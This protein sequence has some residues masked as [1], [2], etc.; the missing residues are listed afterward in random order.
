MKK[1]FQL[2]FLTVL[3]VG[4]GV[5]STACNSSEGWESEPQNLTGTE[6][7]AFS[8]KANAKVLSRLDSVYFSIDLVGGRIFNASPLPYGTR[9][10]SIAVAI[11]ADACSVA[12]IYVTRSGEKQDTVINY[13]TSPDEF[14]DF[15]YGPVRLHLVSA[16]GT[17]Q[18]DYNIAVNVASEVSDSL[19]WDKLQKG[20]MY[21][22]RNMEVSRTVKIKGKA[23]TL[24]SDSR[25]YY[26]K[27][28][29][30]VPAA[31]T[32]GGQWEQE[33]IEPVFTTDTPDVNA[34]RADTSGYLDVETFTA[35][36]EGFLYVIKGNKLYMSTDG[37][38][39]F[40]WVDNDWDNIIAPYR[41]CVL[42]LR[43]RW[44]DWIHV[45]YSPHTGSRERG[46]SAE[47]F[48]FRRMSQAAVFSTKWA[49]KPQIVIAGGEA[50]EGQVYGGAWAY[51]GTK[52]A[53]IN[54][55]L[56]AGTG[57]AMA[58]YPIAE[59]DTMNWT[60]NRREVLIAFGGANEALPLRDVW[61]S[62]DMGVN[63]QKGSSLLQ[64]P[65]YMPFVTGASLLVFDKTLDVNSP[66]ARAVKPITQWECPY[67]YLFGGYDIDGTFSNAYWSGVVNHWTVKPIQ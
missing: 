47:D 17:A 7:T 59:T 63:W 57:Y 20:E 45:E 9:T 16:D 36:E 28:S 44:G 65:E 51:D 23:L 25:G 58:K 61:I 60:V 10:D 55:D 37:G 46:K 3:I 26:A 39:K 21:G 67:L 53:K 49:D 31:Y 27:I 18:R 13:L 62:R 6:V 33:L 29:T 15:S 41:D 11:S 54:D 8:L 50:Y 12:E 4:L 32:G 5:A 56:P 22:T 35:T 38:H 43:Y 19:Y 1:G 24:S 2:Y 52:W 48:P 66:S 40:V 34:S 64:L 14:V 30:F 42:G